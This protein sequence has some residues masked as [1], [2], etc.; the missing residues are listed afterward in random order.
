M[1]MYNKSDVNNIIINNIKIIDILDKKVNDIT[2]LFTNNIEYDNKSNLVNI[3]LDNF[4]EHNK[5]L[6]NIYIN[7]YIYIFLFSTIIKKI[8]CSYFY[9]KRKNYSFYIKQNNIND[10]LI[11]NLYNQNIKLNDKNI[12]FNYLNNQINSINDELIG[13]K[14]ENKMLKNENKMLNNDLI[15]MTILLFVIYYL[16]LY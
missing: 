4:N 9:S 8:D 7:N 5:K 2:H 12:N 14:N 16:F 6:K 10:I 13:L 3:Y 11:I 1:I 15:Y